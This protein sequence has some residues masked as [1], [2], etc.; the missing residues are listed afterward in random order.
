MRAILD[1]LE[2]FERQEVEAHAL[3][4]R[5]WTVCRW[6]RIGKDISALRQ[7]EQNGLV[8]DEA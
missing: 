2:P 4:A 3:R 7:R 5:I 1:N 8:H 6:L